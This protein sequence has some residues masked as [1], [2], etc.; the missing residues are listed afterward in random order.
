MLKVWGDDTYGQISGAPHGNI[1]AVA[2]GAFQSLALRPNGTPVLW[3]LRPGQPPIGPGDIPGV[4]AAENFRTIAIGRDDAVLIRPDGTLMAFGQTTLVTSVPAGSYRAVT[5]AA[6]HAVAIANNGTLIA[7]GSNDPLSLLNVPIGG[8]FRATS[9]SLLYSIALHEDG[10]LYGWGAGARGVYVLE[11][12]T[13]TPQDSTIRYI[14]GQIFKSVAAGNVHALAIRQDGTVEGWGKNHHGAIEPPPHVRFKE[15]DAGWG[16]SIGLSTD[17]TLWGWGRVTDDPGTPPPWTFASQGWA[18]HGNS[19][20]YY[21]PGE[22]FKS[23]AAAA[24][25]VMAIKAGH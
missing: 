16:Y 7:W 15:V 14:P 9:A 2:G 4:I 24:F 3:G 17:G 23:I 21:V 6:K 8:P 1:K 12:W 25:H 22:R 10:T 18:R 5:V 19:E 20:H 13:P 11:N